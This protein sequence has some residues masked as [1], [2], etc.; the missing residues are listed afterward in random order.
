[1]RSIS[2]A[3]S[4]E[5]GTQV[6][7]VAASVR[8]LA[9]AAR[10]AGYQ[11]LALDFFDDTDT[12]EICS[13]NG[14]AEGGLDHGFTWE[15]LIPA[16]DALAGGAEPCGLV[17]G[18]GFEDRTSLLDCLARHWRLLGNRPESVRQVKDPVR[19]A[20]LCATLNIPHPETC[21][22]FPP[23]RAGWLAKRAGGS[24]GT[25]VAPAADIQA[26]SPA[27]YFQRFVEGE[28]VS[29][30]FLA[31]GANINVIGLTRQWTAPAPG[32]PH[33]FGGIM[34]P[35]R[36][37]PRLERQLRQAAASVTA[38]C[39]LRGL[40]SIDFLVMD[41]AYVLLEVNPRPGAALDIFEDDTGSSFRA[42]IDACC[43]HLPAR[44]FE[45]PDA[46]AA[47]IAYVPDGICSFMPEFGWPDWAADRSKP[48]SPLRSHDPLCTIKA[49]AADPL[50]A[51]ALAKARADLLLGRL[52]HI[53]DQN[54]GKREEEIS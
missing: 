38:A 15:N 7:I 41:R 40:N 28:P 44:S 31:D 2:R 18:A 46:A 54:T 48:G 29:V 9:A 20:S 5:A 3:R 21:T 45:F 32:E 24:G 12:R 47:A 52:A 36:V 23:E 19:L 25:H 43:G 49:K 17:Y 50:E 10:R 27:V 4:S 11:P 33:R 30:Q 51:H 6:L 16:L 39:G 14:C 35:A 53:Q 42:H 8:A 26:V 1:M 37:A 13:A 22:G 34:R